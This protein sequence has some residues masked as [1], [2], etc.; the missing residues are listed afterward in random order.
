M[1]A[2][3]GSWAGVRN[4]S[5]GQ[6]G[7]GL[8]KGRGGR[9]AARGSSGL[10]GGASQAPVQGVPVPGYRRRPQPSFPELPDPTGSQGQQIPRP[11]EAGPVLGS[12]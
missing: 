4:N 12:P 9:G 1:R 11:A 5:L 10:L 3:P 2:R 8:A 6:G 7:A